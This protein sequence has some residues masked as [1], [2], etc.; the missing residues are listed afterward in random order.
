M[1]ETLF[2]PSGLTLTVVPQ[3][4]DGITLDTYCAQTVGQHLTTLCQEQGF[5]WDE[6][7]DAATVDLNAAVRLLRRPLDPTPYLLESHG[8]H[9]ALERRMCRKLPRQRLRHDVIERL[10]EVG[11]N[12][13]RQR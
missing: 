8:L 7:L 5:T 10:A 2:I 4:F 9:I 3:F 1:H 12:R 11:A 6:N 13:W